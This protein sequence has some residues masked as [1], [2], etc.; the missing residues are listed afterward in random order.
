MTDNNPFLAQFPNLHRLVN[1]QLHAWPEHGKFLGQ[2]FPDADDSLL[3]LSETL[4]SLIVKLAGED[5]ERYCRDYRW[6]CENFIEEEIHFRRTG[7]YRLKTFEEAYTAVYGNAEYMARYIDGILLTQVFW[8][9]QVNAL[10]YYINE[11]LPSLKP[12]FDYLEIGPGHGLYLYFAAQ[13]KNSGG[14]WASDASQSSLDSTRRTLDVLGVKKNFEL[15]LQNILDRPTDSATFD[16]VTISEVLEHLDRPADA[17]DHIFAIT[18]PQGR[19]FI[20]VPVNSPAPDHIFLWHSPEEVVDLV[21]ERGFIIED[22]RCA[23]TTGYTEERAR[24]RK[25]TINSLIVAVH[26]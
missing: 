5:I 19:V 7:E 15:K 12:G 23:P 13:Q 14:L 16:A 8:R 9:N 11:Y 2:R 22:T 10:D 17:L 25:V 26:P 24:K 18:R 20:N 4:A 3:P 21:R 6:L 1:A